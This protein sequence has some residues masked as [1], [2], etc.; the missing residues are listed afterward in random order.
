VPDEQ[1]AAELLDAYLAQ[2]QSGGKPDRD[3]LLRAHPDLASAIKCLEAL[4]D[5]APLPVDED[6]EGK[7]IGQGPHPSPLPEGEGTRGGPP[8]DFGPYEL[9]DE[10]GRGGMGVVYRARQKDLDRVVAIKMILASHLASSEHVRRFQIEARAAAKLRHSNIV[11]IHEVGQCHGQHY[12]TMEYIEGE[13]LAQRLARGP[14]PPQAAARMLSAVARAVEHLHQQSIVH[15]DLKPSNILLDQDE[16]PYVTDFGLAKVFVPGSEM[17]ATGVIAGTPSYMAPEQAS[18]RGA[19]V[20]PAADVYSLGAIL[21]ELLTGRPPFQHDNPLDTLLD[22]LDSEP[23]PPRRLNPHVPH[24]L[25]LICLKCLAKSPDERYASA[26]ALADDL[27]RFA[28]GEPLAVKPPHLGQRI[29]N[30]T[31]RQPALALR[32]AALGTFFVVGTIL[33][34]GGTVNR[35]FYL[36]TSVLLATWAGAS[37]VCQQFLDSR[38]WSI[39]A[40]FVWGMLDSIVFLALLLVGNGA[41]SAMVT[42][43]P[44]LIAGSGLWFRVRF[45]WFMTALSLLSYGLIVADFYLRRSEEFRSQFDPLF[46]RHVIFAISLVVLGSIVAYLV[47]RVRTLS[48]FCGRQLP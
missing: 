35:E 33:F 17:T 32:L 43:Y 39:P 45:V 11:H 25:E 26:A 36:K 16:Q 20:G 9:L 24:G 2:L 21:Y 8:R 18:G 27:D 4:D 46:S 19:E 40:R 34:G 23:V 6:G 15:R 47:H 31:R 41:A 42:G 5:L 7:V 29:V 48:S 13:S 30:W 14:V 22:V 37:V 3:A 10:I 12:F 44:L 38:R 28:Q 1:H